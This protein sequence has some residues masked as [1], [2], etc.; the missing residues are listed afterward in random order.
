MRRPETS[1]TENSKPNKLKY[2][3]NILN[4]HSLSNADGAMQ[5]DSKAYRNC[6]KTNKSCSETG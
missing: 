1:A 4:N 2:E 5:R 3:S 6:R